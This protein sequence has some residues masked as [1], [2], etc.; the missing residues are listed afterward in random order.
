[1]ENEARISILVTDMGNGGAFCGK[2]SC[3]LDHGDPRVKLPACCPQCG[4]KFTGRDEP[5]NMG[6]S[7][8]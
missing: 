5:I 7:D 2:C 8:F 3:D 4:A 6:G 1:M